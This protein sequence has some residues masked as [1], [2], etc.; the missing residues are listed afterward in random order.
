MSFS[1]E[2]ALRASRHAFETTSGPEPGWEWCH[3]PLPA[4]EQGVPSGL[5]G[6]G[7]G[8]WMPRDL[9]QIHG[10]LQSEDMGRMC[11][12]LGDAAEWL[13]TGPFVEGWFDLYDLYEKWA[14]TP[15]VPAGWNHTEAARAN[16]RGTRATNG[17]KGKQHSEE[18]LSKMRTAHRRIAAQKKLRKMAAVDPLVGG[19][20]D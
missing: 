17:L 7:E 20:W 9:H 16:M 18:A 12:W 4:R 15:P 1:H 3:T 14:R 8:V 13:R 6:G 19:F 5:V 10:I 11:F 2:F